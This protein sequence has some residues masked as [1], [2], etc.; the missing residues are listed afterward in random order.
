MKEGTPVSCYFNLHK[1]VFS[2]QQGRLPIKHFSW[3]L[4]RSASF[5]VNLSGR[6]RVLEKK[7]KEVHAY[8]KGIFLE[9]ENLLSSEIQI[10][11]HFD[12]SVP[13]IRYNPYLYCYFFQDGFNAPIQEA[14]LVLLCNKQVFKLR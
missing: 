14:D 1:K 13:R 2:V 6:E 8:V 9:G 10:P 4:L 12:L 7:R 3:L 11:T 5:S